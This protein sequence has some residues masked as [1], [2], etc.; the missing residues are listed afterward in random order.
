MWCQIAL[1]LSRDLTCS[2]RCTLHIAV[3]TIRNTI[4]YNFDCT[5]GRVRNTGSTSVLP[6]STGNK[7]NGTPYCGVE[8]SIYLFMVLPSLMA[9]CGQWVLLRSAVMMAD[10]VWCGLWA[11]LGVLT[12]WVLTILNV[13]TVLTTNNI[14]TSWPQNWN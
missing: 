6:R 13:L 5:Q 3:T 7:G 10:L 8:V 2:Q 9:M 11:M 12:G 14:Q 4:I 1:I